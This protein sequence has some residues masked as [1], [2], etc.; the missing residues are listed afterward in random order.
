MKQQFYLPLLLLLSLPAI[1]QQLH[2]CGTPPYKSEWLKHY[3]QNPAAFALQ[4]KNNGTIYAPITLHVVGTDN[5]TGYID[6][7]KLMNGMCSLNNDF[8]DAQLHFFIDGDIR[9]IDSTGWYA[10]SD[11]LEGAD[12]MFANNAINTINCYVVSSAAGNAGYNL[13]YAGIALTKSSASGG[14][15]WAHEIGHNLSIQHPFLGWENTEYQFSS[16]TPTE[17]YYDYSYFK[18]TL[19]RDTTIIDT[20]LVELVDGSNCT[21]AADGF[22]DTPP[23]YL[24]GYFVGYGCNSQGYSSEPQKDPNGVSFQ[25]DATNIMSYSSNSCKSKFTPEQIAAMRA[26]LQ[27]EKVNYLSNQNPIRD[28]FTTPPILL[29]PTDAGV[30]QFDDVHLEWSS[31]PPATHYVV[32]VSRFSSFTLLAHQS[33]TTDTTVNLTNLGNGFTYYWRVKAFNQGYTCAPSSPNQTFKTSDLTAI[34]NIQRVESLKV[35]PTLLESGQ[36]LQIELKIQTPLE[37]TV[38]LHSMAGQQLSHQVFSLTAGK[39]L[40][41]IALNHFASGTYLMSFQTTTGVVTKRI[42][43][44]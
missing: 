34:D 29:S 13:P 23:D 12:M 21:V 35:Y 39:H 6:F 7:M 38:Q 41:T 19:I 24:S 4:A 20:A 32:Q 22:C 44:Y 14:H 15:T 30:T 1:G 42:V 43:V 18:D 2:P 16:P 8:I 37:L 11:V 10:H 9:F 40:Q 5:G 31:L 26:N 36:S 33:I 25:T 3:Q 17:V 28:T 27:T